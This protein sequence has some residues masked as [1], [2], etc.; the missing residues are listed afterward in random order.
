[1]WPCSATT[2]IR[3]FSVG[4]GSSS[5]FLSTVDMRFVLDGVPLETERT[6]IGRFST[7]PA[8]LVEQAF[9]VGFGAFLPPGVLS[10]GTHQLQT[11]VHDPLFG[12]FDFTIGFD[13][14]TC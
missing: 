6:A 4:T 11:F 14:V 2:T 5:I 13:V 12:D 3:A 8:E 1:M 7:P 9:A 10:V